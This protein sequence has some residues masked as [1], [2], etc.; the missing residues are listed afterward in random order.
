[1][2]TGAGGFGDID[3]SFLAAVAGNNA[4]APPPEDVLTSF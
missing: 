1:M 3:D 2:G 4:A